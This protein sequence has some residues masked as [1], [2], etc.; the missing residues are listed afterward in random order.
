MTRPKQ[1]RR[2]RVLR[3]EHDLTQLRTAALAKINPGRLSLI[4]NGHIEPN[5]DERIRIARVFK[6]PVH[7]VFPPAITR[8]EGR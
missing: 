8:A 7:E 3:A 2:L 6:L 5:P 4:E 1:S